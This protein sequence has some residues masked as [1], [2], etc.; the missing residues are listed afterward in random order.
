MMQ[1][2]GNAL[3]LFGECANSNKNPRFETIAGVPIGYTYIYSKHLVHLLNTQWKQLSS[4][5]NYMPN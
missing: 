4:S 1:G 3:M 2:L 5:I